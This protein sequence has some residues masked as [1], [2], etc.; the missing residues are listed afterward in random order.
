MARQP[1]KLKRDINWF[2]T[3]RQRD[4]MSMSKSLRNTNPK[5]AQSYYNKA[6]RMAANR[7]RVT[8]GPL[9]KEAERARIFS[10]DN[11]ADYVA[12]VK[13]R[14]SS[15][16]AEENFLRH[17]NKTDSAEMAYQYMMSDLLQ[18]STGESKQAFNLDGEKYGPD[19]D[20]WNP[21]S[22]VYPLA[23][24]RLI[25]VSVRLYLPFIARFED[26]YGWIR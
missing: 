6:I 10:I 22:K 16:A 24:A 9:G 21:N 3:K 20:I 15:K 25:R 19:S 7:T 5:K 13:I 11:E 26:R 4:Y 12:L 18:L 23:Y 17:Y 14:L 1:S 2:L 8:Y